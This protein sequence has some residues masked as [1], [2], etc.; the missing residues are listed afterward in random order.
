MKTLIISPHLDDESISCGGLIQTRPSVHVAV[1]HG[2][3]YDYQDASPKDISNELED[4]H[5]ASEILHFDPSVSLYEEGEPGRV[6][7]YPLLQVVENLLAAEEFTEVVIPASDDLNQDHRHLHHVMSIA[8]RPVNLGSVTRVLEFI[9]LDGVQR[10]PNYFV[11]LTEKLVKNKLKAVAAYRR[12][13]RTGTSP[14][15]PKNMVAQMRVWGAMC[16]HEYAEGYRLK[17]ERS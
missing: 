7:Y 4:F 12:E 11:P 16:G 9:A 8:L 6:G 2:R 3:K 5:A 17:L 14:R 13:R 10:V 1:I 15:S